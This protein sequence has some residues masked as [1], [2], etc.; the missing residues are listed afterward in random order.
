[1]RSSCNRHLEKLAYPFASPLDGAFIVN[2]T[3]YIISTK[4][5][6]YSYFIPIIEKRTNFIAER[7]K[8]NFSFPITLPVEFR[9][10]LSSPA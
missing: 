6:K 1:M 8:A 3:Y 2:S 7:P 4:S 9:L 5:G 10:L